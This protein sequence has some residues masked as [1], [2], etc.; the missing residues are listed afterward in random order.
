MKIKIINPN[1]TWSLTN[2]LQIE[3][4]KYALP[5]TEIIS[6]SPRSGPAS[7]ESFYDDYLSIPGIFEEIRK[8]DQE[9][10][11]DAYVIACFGDPGLLGAREITSAPVIGIAEA[12][13][14]MA[15]MIAASF[16]IV[17]TLP[18]T[19]LMSEHVV[20]H[21]G[22]QHKCRN[23]RTTPLHV[24]D[25][26]NDKETSV[27]QI[28]EECRKA[29]TEDQAEAIVLGCAAMSA[30]REYIQEACGIPVIDGT[31]AAVKFC[32]ALVGLGV[33]TSKA[34]TFATPEKKAFSGILQ[35]FGS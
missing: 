12:A 10:D 8:G 33:T 30:Q 29:V 7:I 9:E 32:E 6:V 13:M 21:N 25:V 17:T 22:M 28:I 18:R 5:T 19:R 26:Q 31:L 35:S 4:Q 14:Q 20:L 1:T 34:L 24:L 27:R 16:T 2:D 23:I 15:S 11:I 3:A